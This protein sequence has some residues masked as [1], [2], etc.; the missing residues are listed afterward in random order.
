[1]RKVLL[2]DHPSVRG[3]GTTFVGASESPLSSCLP[4]EALLNFINKFSFVR[5]ERLIH[6]SAALIVG[7]FE[8]FSL[9]G[10]IV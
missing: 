1:M 3:R 7:I 4:D 8:G 2:D 9:L 6:G 5:F 10:F